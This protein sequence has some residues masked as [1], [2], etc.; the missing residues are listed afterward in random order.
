MNGDASPSATGSSLA[1]WR[2]AILGV[3]VALAVAVPAWLVLSQKATVTGIVVHVDV[4]SLT[5]VRGFDL[6]TSDGRILS[7]EI[8]QLDMSPP[9]FNPQHLTVH[10]ATAQPVTVTY[11][12]VDGRL[13]AVRMVDAPAA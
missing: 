4:V 13:V 11:E 2:L 5:D 3:V 10:A 8:G 1:R 7:F 6:R 9:G 12:T